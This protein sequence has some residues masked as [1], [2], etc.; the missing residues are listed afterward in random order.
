M[1]LPNYK[2]SAIALS[3]L[4]FSAIS[5]ADVDKA[6]DAFDRADLAT[7]FAEFKV[8]AES[9]E[10][11]AALIYGSL[12]LNT[13]LPEY[14]QAKGHEWL[15]QAADAGDARAAYNL[16]YHLFKSLSNSSWDSDIVKDPATIAKF[17]KYIQMA[18]DAN[19]PEAYEFTIN[20]GMSS[21]ELFGI[22]DPKELVALI[23]KVHE[24]QPTGMANYYMGVMAL[25]GH[26]LFDDIPYEPQKAA[27]YLEAAYQQGTKNS[28]YLLKDLYN[29]DYENFPANKDK[30]N[31]YAKI[32]Y[33]NFSEIN[34][35]VYFHV[36]DISPLNIRT[37]KVADDVVAKLK[38]QSETHANAARAIAAFTNDPKVAKQYLQKAIDLGDQSA[39][40]AM[41]YLD[42]G[43][44]ADKTDVID[45]IIPLAESGDLAA[46]LFL[47]QKLYG[48]DAIPHL[49]RAA[50]LGDFVSMVNLSRHYGDQALLDK[51]S[52]KQALN[53]YNQLIQQFPD[54]AT[55]YREKAWLLYNEVGYRDQ[56]MPEIFAGLHRAIELNPEDSKALMHLAQIYHIDAQ[57]GDAAKALALYQQIITLNNDEVECHQARLLQAMM[58]K[59]GEGNVAKDEQAA[60]ILFS[61]IIEKYPEDYQAT[62]E[63][64]DSYHH[65][66]GIEKD[67]N[68][69]IELYR[70][71]TNMNAHVPLGML[72]AQS[73]DA[74][75][76]AEGLDL[77]ISVA[78]SQKV[79]PETLALLLSFKDQSPIVQEWL[80]KLVTVEPYRT[81]FDA[82]AEI[83]ESCDAGNTL[84]CVNYARWL[85]EKNID[86]EQ[87]LQL[88]NASVDK[89]DVHAV[90]VLLDQARA[91][92]D[93][94]T[95]KILIETLVALE[96][97]DENYQQLAEFYFFQLE[98]DLAE[99]TYQKI[100]NLSERAE[101]DQSRIPAEREYLAGL[102][103]RAEQ[104]DEEAV[105]TLFYLYQNNKRADLA[106]EAIEQWGDL[107]NEETLNEWMHLLDQSA[108]P[109]NIS[110]AT[111]QLAQNVLIDQTTDFAALYQRYTEA[112]DRNIKRQQMLDWI[113]QYAK[114]N[115]ED[116][117]IYLDSMKGFDAQLQMSY[118]SNKQMRQDALDELSYAYQIGMG[119]QRDS[120]KHFEIL[121]QLAEL[122][123]ESAAY[124]LAEAYRTGKDVPMNWDKAVSYYKL[125]PDEGYGDALENIDFYKDVVAPAQ[126]GDM[127]AAFKLGK[128]YL[129]DYTYSDQPN[130][131]AEGYRLVRQAAE[132]GS[133]DAQYFLS[134]SYSYSGLTHYQRNEWLQK[135]ADNGHAEAQQ[136]LAQ[137]L[138]IETPLSEAQIKEVIRL[139]SAAAKT[140][141]EA[142]LN[143]FRFYY[144]QNK[145][146]DADKILATLSDEEK[147]KQYTNIA[148]WYE[149]SHGALPRS[150]QKALE[151][152]QKSYEGG[153]LK[154]GINM[155]SLYLNDPFAPKKDE[156]MA[157][158]VEILNQAM[159]SEN[160]YALD[161]VIMAVNS[162]MK[163][164]DG[165]DQS[166]ELTQFGLDWAE[167]ILAEGNVYA[168]VILSDYYLEKGDTAKAYFYLKLIDSWAIEELVEKMSAEE[169]DA[170]NQAVEAYKAQV[171]W[172]Y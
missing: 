36:R 48:N 32:Y 90:R 95:Q 155:L 141:P 83:K 51:T 88:L 107:N 59:Y 62:Y 40:I 1:K 13:S 76:Q 85:L 149:Y 118:S 66:K 138:E 27:Q 161:D 163:G 29:G 14:D 124:Q 18:L 110:K 2:R 56:V 157:L 120:V 172:L 58:L 53:G 115:A 171:N 25:Q 125:L 17:Q 140:L 75:L 80:Y 31:D 159:D 71:T 146:E 23:T 116:A 103:A 44:Y 39:A 147:V 69:A 165:F 38:A 61:E 112:K 145:I 151:F 4:Y 132:K 93:Y 121:E 81:N 20:N 49:I 35:P 68:K 33:E 131:R 37:Q 54:D 108:D 156:G 46:N 50:E 134:L 130:I 111:K 22:E 30:Y 154:S 63:L 105:R 92:H 127:N 60:N 78:E 11:D 19:L 102:I 91:K 136:M 101:Y 100:E 73:D 164:T 5:W 109:I 87:A 98:Y 94:F 6:W 21:Q 137:Y 64:A 28:V 135:S 12:L 57:Y 70:L 119:T 167:K 129:E 106:I 55:A 82:L 123:D 34:D 72:L 166:P 41:Y 139:Y 113:T 24:I 43:W 160:P 7:S 144:G 77:I 84:A 3:L 10:Q 79:E 128:Y 96:P 158:F 126:K 74:A 42:E 170:Q 99:Q 52:L 86:P 122:K 16:A 104:K 47:S 142:Q 162:A 114:I 26:K 45:Q 148:R 150:N 9:N 89:G 65:G 143:L 168:G 15:Q 133:V 97:N 152:Y 117:K 8:S 153:H 67:L 169:I